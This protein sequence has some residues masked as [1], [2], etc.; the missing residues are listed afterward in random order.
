MG[1]KPT[2]KATADV[3]PVALPVLTG[4]R[5]A[6]K[7]QRQRVDLAVGINV[8]AFYAATGL[9]LDVPTFR[10]M[11]AD[12]VFMALDAIPGAT[13]DKFPSADFETGINGYGYE[14]SLDLAKLDWCHTA[15]HA[16]DCPAH[17]EAP[18]A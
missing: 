12:T 9:M 8:D 18:V 15:L 1:D 10:Q 3:P 5:L 14:E 4:H 11:V 6:G 16:D 7:V 13:I 2:V 17:A